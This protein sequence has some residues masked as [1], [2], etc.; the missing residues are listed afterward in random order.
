MDLSDCFALQIL[1][2]VMFLLMMVMMVI[3]VMIIMSVLMVVWCDG[4]L[5]M[6]K[7]T[8]VSERVTAEQPRLADDCRREHIHIK[9]QNTTWSLK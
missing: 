7:A 9:T 2:M 8:N 1:A 3:I 6:V 4:D 5:L